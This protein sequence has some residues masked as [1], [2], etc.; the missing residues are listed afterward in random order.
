[1][2]NRSNKHIFKLSMRNYILRPLHQY[3]HFQGRFES[4][5]ITPV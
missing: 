2:G 3:F 1:M 5:T 4:N